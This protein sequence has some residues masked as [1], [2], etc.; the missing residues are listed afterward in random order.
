M[1]TLKI[2]IASYEEMKARTVAIASGEYR[3]IPGEPKTWFPSVESAAN[4]LASGNLELL[5]MIAAEC[6]K[7]NLSGTLRAA[8]L[9]AAVDLGI[10]DAE[11][12][13]TKPLTD[14]LLRDIAERG[15]KIAKAYRI[16]RN[17]PINEE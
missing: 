13:R 14:E 8:R 5:K 6:Q 2:G 16:K 9:R 17:R 11:H 7:L 12:H 10:A 4:V 3:P 15:R 1:K